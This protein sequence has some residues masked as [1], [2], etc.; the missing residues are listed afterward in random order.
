M[1]MI[2]SFLFFQILNISSF[3]IRSSQNIRTSYKIMN[4]KFLHTYI[5][6]EREQGD[7]EPEIHAKLQSIVENEYNVRYNLNMFVID[8]SSDIIENVFFNKIINDKKYT[9]I[10]NSGIYLATDRNKYYYYDII[11]KNGWTFLNTV[12]SNLFSHKYINIYEEP[13]Y[14]NTNFICDFFNMNVS[15]NILTINKYLLDFI[16]ISNIKQYISSIINENNIK[17]FIIS[18]PILV[19]KNTFHYKNEY[20]I[21]DHNDNIHNIKV[22][23]EFIFPST[24][25][26]RI[27]VNEKQVTLITSA[28][29]INNKTTKLYIKIYQN[30][31]ENN[32]LNI[33]NN[34]LNKFKNKYVQELIVTT[35][36][37]LIKD[38]VNDAENNVCGEN[39]VTKSVLNITNVYQTL[40]NKYI[41]LLT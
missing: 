22:T 23:N 10:K 12:T 39:N 8:K 18:Q 6:E 11:D 9:I 38:I 41:Y 30:C 4:M 27:K 5:K 17:P 34:F 35:C 37:N 32:D 20:I 24:V 2:I 19:S 33:I 36:L 31:L 29:P 13:E 14:N 1:I 25:I 40:Y 28:T 21:V 15:S 7:N 3:N 16:N 26:I